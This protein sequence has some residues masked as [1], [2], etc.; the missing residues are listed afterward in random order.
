MKQKNFCWS[1]QLRS[2]NPMFNSVIETLSA[3]CTREMEAKQTL[4]HFIENDE[5]SNSCSNGPTFSEY[6]MSFTKKTCGWITYRAPRRNMA[7]MPSFCRLD[8]CSFQI[9]AICEQ[10]LYC[11]EH[12]RRKLTHGGGME[13]MRTVD[14]L[15]GHNSNLW[16]V[17][18]R[19]V[20]TSDHAWAKYISLVSTQSSSVL[21]NPVQLIHKGQ[22][23]NKLAKKNPTVQMEVMEII[24]QNDLIKT[25]PL[26]ILAKICQYL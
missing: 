10:W 3:P 24:I 9:W 2:R 13:R 16:D 6:L 5:P 22:H 26:K 17:Y 19:S 23:W 18:L 25:L 8:I 15:D 7:L 11:V 21:P 1:S 4:N 14:S 12:G 20:R